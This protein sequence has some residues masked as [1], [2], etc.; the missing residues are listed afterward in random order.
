M[1]VLLVV[2][3]GTDLLE[4]D[5]LAEF[6]VF[7]AAI[8]GRSDVVDFVAFPDAD[9]IRQGPELFAKFACHVDSSIW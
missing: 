2:L 6:I 7:G 4:D 1:Q 9:Q 8:V 3:D 5:A